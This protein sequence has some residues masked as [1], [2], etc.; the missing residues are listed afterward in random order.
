[1]TS[2]ICQ[3]D[4][5][6][7]KYTLASSG[8]DSG[9]KEED[10]IKS[11]FYSDSNH[12]SYWQITFSKPVIARSYQMCPNT[13]LYDSYT[14]SWDI[15]YS[16]GASLRYLQTDSVS[17]RPSGAIKFSFSKSILLK[18]LRITSSTTSNNG[19][20]WLR[21]G[22]FDL[23]GPSG[24]INNGENRQKVIRNAIILMMPLTAL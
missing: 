4:A 19:G 8:A 1:M 23:F 12:P 20:Q 7:L 16:T 11:S 3:F 18:S 22:N 2:I 6:G 15:S 9:T 5:K 13:P 14:S 21:V 17:S 24:S 10:A